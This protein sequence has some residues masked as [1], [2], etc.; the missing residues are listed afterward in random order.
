MS[1]SEMEDINDVYTILCDTRAR[2]LL[3]FIAD[4]HFAHTLRVD[5]CSLSF[6]YFL[7]LS[8]KRSVAD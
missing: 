6:V 3:L 4:K 5:L 2:I 7:H 1:N 8:L